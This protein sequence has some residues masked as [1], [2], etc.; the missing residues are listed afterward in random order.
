MSGDI[1]DCHSLGKGLLPTGVQ[2]EAIR[3]VVEHNGTC[4]YTGYVYLLRVLKIYYGSRY[5]TNVWEV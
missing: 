1:F 4:K 2:W 5:D 3:D